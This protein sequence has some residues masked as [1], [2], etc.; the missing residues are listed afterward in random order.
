M[1]LCVLDIEI[2][3]EEIK[4]FSDAEQLRQ[5]PLLLGLICR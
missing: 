3:R 4:A 5:R 1:L 2:S